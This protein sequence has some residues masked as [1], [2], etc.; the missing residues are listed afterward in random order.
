MIHY[1]WGPEQF[2]H[3]FVVQQA[4]APVG[5]RI[6][7]WKKGLR[8]S[9]RMDENKKCWSK[10]N[11]GVEN[12]TG[13]KSKSWKFLKTNSWMSHLKKKKRDKVHL[14]FLKKKQAAFELT[15]KFKKKKSIRTKFFSD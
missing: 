13:N 14:N 12:V 2:S 10:K 3:V 4:T 7:E 8:P 1:V 9:S 6:R 5:I 15:T 11:R